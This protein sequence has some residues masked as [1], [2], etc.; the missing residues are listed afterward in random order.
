MPLSLFVFLGF[1][2]LPQINSLVQMSRR[3][4]LFKERNIY[5]LVQEAVRVVHRHV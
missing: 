5:L 4:R 1:V 2:E 3:N